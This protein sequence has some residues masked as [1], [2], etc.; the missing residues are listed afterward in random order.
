[1]AA[2]TWSSLAAWAGGGLSA[3]WAAVLAHVMV[4]LVAP[5]WINDLRRSLLTGSFS[6]C[7]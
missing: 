1:M 7:L 5:R 6:G 2:A 3:S 4:N